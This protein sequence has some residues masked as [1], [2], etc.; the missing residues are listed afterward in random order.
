MASFLSLGAPSP[1][2]PGKY[3]STPQGQSTGRGAPFLFD[4]PHP[5]PG[6]LGPPEARLALV[7]SQY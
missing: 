3:S 4:D 5:G 7:S 1:V 6:L 2:Q